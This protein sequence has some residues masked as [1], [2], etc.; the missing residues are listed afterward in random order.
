MFSSSRGEKATLDCVRM[1]MRDYHWE[2]VPRGARQ[3]TMSK[4]AR[5]TSIMT[6]AGHTVKNTLLRCRFSPSFT[7][8]QVEEYTELLILYKNLIPNHF[9]LFRVISTQPVQE[10]EL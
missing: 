3:D 8:G 7:T 5:D 10:A 2:S 4:L 9:F 1:Q 6:F